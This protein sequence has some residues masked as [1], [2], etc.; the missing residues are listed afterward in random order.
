MKDKF[1]FSWQVSPTIMNDMMNTKNRVQ[2]DRVTQAFLPMKKMN[3]AELKK[4]YE[5]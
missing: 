2:L 1:G 4:A 5:G 3:I